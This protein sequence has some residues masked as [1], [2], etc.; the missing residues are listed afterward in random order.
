M[1][2]ELFSFVSLSQVVTHLQAFQGAGVHRLFEEG[3][4]RLATVLRPVHR[5]IRVA[6]HVRRLP[7]RFARYGDAYAWS[8]EHLP[9]T[10]GEGCSQLLQDAF[11]YANG[12]SLITVLEQED[13][14]VS[15]EACDGVLGPGYFL[16]TAAHQNE[17][18][19]AHL[20]PQ[21]VVYDFE[22]VQIHE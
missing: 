14:L 9:T 19:V 21:R 10:E 22:V 7:A 18:L 4:A 20:V 6:Q 3:V 2:H 16:Q 12:T 15:A 1:D 17:Q 13:E 8:N 11:R 5:Q